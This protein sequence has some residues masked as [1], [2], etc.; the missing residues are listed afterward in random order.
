MSRAAADADFLIMGV[1]VLKRWSGLPKRAKFIQYM[2]SGFGQLP[3]SVLN[4]SGM[5]VASDEGPLDLRRRA[6]V[7][8]MLATLRRIPASMQ[9]MRER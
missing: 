2:S 7:T 5:P 4:D 8:L 6:C 3:L 1:D 9:L